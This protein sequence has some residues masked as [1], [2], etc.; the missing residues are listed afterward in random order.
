MG[1]SVFG[2]GVAQINVLVTT[3]LASFLAEGSVS[4]LY[5]ADRLME[6]P[7]G[8]FAIA[9]A[10]VVLPTLSVHAAKQDYAHLPDPQMDAL[11]AYLGSLRE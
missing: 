1:P 7:L 4:Y 2:L 3:L 6:F 8:V 11:L 9:V 10:T 5:Y